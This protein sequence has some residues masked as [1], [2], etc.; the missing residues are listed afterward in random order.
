VQALDKIWENVAGRKLHI[1]GGIGARGAGEAF[2][3]D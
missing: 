3:A 2:G 1:T